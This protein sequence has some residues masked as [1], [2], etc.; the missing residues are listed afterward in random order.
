[1]KSKKE[2]SQ[3]HPYGNTNVDIIFPRFGLYVKFASKL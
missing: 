1:M 2:K 3:I